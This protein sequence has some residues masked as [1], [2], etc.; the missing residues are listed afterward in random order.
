MDKP[1][2]KLKAWQLGIEIAK[3]IYRITKD[4]PAEEKFGLVLQMRKC[5]VS[6]PSNVSEGAARSSKKEFV[7]FLYVS[8]GSLSELDTQLELA[9]DPAYLDHR[10]WAETDAKS[11]E[12]DK[13]LTGLIRH[14]K[15]KE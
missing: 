2:K 1:H 9:K 13:V 14:Q 10:C 12:E 15:S 5:A 7:N 4:F 6:I 3:D 11:I 8:L